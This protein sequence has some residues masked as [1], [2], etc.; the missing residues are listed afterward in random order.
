[1]K[2]SIWT[3]ALITGLIAG[4]LWAQTPP[5]P[6]PATPPVEA[7]TEPTTAPAEQQIATINGVPVNAKWFTQM[8]MSVGGSRVLQ[9]AIDLMVV[10]QE[11]NRNF[12]PMHGPEFEKLVQAEIDR[13]LDALVEQGVKPEE[14]TKVFFTLLQQS[15]RTED[16]FLVQ[17]R[18]QAGLRM[19][20]AGR[21]DPPTEK[22]ITDAFDVLYGP[23]V[24]V[25]VVTART[26]NDMTNIRKRL[27]NGEAFNDVIRSTPNLVRVQPQV[28]AENT[29]YE[30]DVDKQIKAAA[31]AAKVGTLSN[32]VPEITQGGE[33]FH[34]VFVDKQIPKD[35]TAKLSDPAIRARVEKIV[36]TTKEQRWM[37]ATAQVLHQN[38]KVDIKDPIL[39]RQYQIARELQQAAQGAAT[40]P[41]PEAPK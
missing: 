9:H 33:L 26:R 1:M 24:E 32:P 14:R 3:T 15:G 20:S 7:T 5:A 38:L 16:E 22:E 18:I 31:L 34:A 10:E 35:A 39:S 2:R 13:T 29:T 6:T 23:R 37:A 8:L 19:L 41:A 27:E 17:M 11:A 21:V 12:K 30:R 28:I 4:T 25:R 36:R 40:Q